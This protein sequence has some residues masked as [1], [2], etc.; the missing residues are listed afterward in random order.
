MPT[1]SEKTVLVVDDEPDV[2]FFLRAALEDAGF[3][4]VTASNG[5]DALKKVKEHR[6]DFIS[7][8]LVMPKKSGI[9]FLYELR[10]NKDWSRIPVVIVTAHAK[11]ELGSHDL[12]E[13][14]DGK[15]LSGPHTYLEKPVSAENF[16]NMVK[17]ELGIEIEEG[18]SATAGPAPASDAETLRKQVQALLASADPEAL[19]KAAEILRGQKA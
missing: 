13:I 11:D 2:V 5:D 14:L 1:P 6:V 15:T 17:R 10:H 16:V 4:V 7:C 12:R 19:K 8:D 9:K 3:N 18:V